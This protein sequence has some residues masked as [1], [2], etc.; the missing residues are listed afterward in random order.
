MPEDLVEFQ[1]CLLS[2]YAQNPIMV[3]LLTLEPVMV[4]LNLNGRCLIVPEDVLEYLPN[5][6]N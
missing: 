5:S 2:S 3:V 4:M 1:S 6:I